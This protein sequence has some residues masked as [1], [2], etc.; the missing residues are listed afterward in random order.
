MTNKD[1]SEIFCYNLNFLLSF[2]L[3]FSGR[4]FFYSP[5][6]PF[7]LQSN[8]KSFSLTSLK[9]KTKK[10]KNCAEHRSEV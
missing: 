1:N 6:I 4:N 2:F 10:K 3:E 8:V 7:Y 5:S 9:A